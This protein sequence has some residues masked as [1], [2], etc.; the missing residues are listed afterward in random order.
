MS[1][2][3]IHSFAKD[4][5]EA[6]GKAISTATDQLGPSGDFKAINV[7]PVV[8]VVVVILNGCSFAKPKQEVG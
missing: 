3:D 2:S 4:V 5:G 1:E 6:V 7:I 8:P